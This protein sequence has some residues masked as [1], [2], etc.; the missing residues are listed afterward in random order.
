MTAGGCP[1]SSVGNSSNDG[2][3]LATELNTPQLKAKS[4]KHF[5]PWGMKTQNQNN[6][7]EGGADLLEL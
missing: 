7:K 6:K 5:L 3:T 2:C 4:G 1:K